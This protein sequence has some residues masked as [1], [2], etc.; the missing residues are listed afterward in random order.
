MSP[1]SRQ[2]GPPWHEMGFTPRTVPSILSRSSCQEVVPSGHKAASLGPIALRSAPNEAG[3]SQERVVPSWSVR[4]SRAETGKEDLK[5]L[6]V[7]HSL[8]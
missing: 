2:R 1:R 6:P 8:R 7:P 3:Q 4:K 5:A